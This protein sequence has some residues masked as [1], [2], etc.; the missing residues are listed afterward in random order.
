[1]ESD[2]KKNGRIKLNKRSLTQLVAA[3]LYNCNIKGF[4]KSSIYK[5]DLKGVCVP[6][7][8]CYSCPGAVASCPLGSL[9]SGLLSSRYKIPYYVLGLLILFGLL[10]GRF[11]CGFLCPFGFL[12]DLLDKLARK[13][14]LPELKKSRLTRGLSYLKYVILAVF[15]VAIPLV[16]GVAKGVILPGFCSLNLCIFW[17]GILR[18]LLFLRG[19]L[20]LL[21]RSHSNL[22]HLFPVSKPVHRLVRGHIIKGLDKQKFAN[23]EDDGDRAYRQQV[24]HRVAALEDHMSRQGEQQHFDNASRRML[25]KH[26]DELN[27]DDQIERALKEMPV[28]YSA[29]AHRAQKRQFLHKRIHA[30]DKTEGHDD[31]YTDFENIHQVFQIRGNMMNPVSYTFIAFMNTI[32]VVIRHIIPLS[33][34]SSPRHQLITTMILY[35]IPA[36]F[37]RFFWGNATVKCNITFIDGINIEGAK[38]GFQQ[39]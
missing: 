10:F 30:N 4:M 31:R 38:Y 25:D 17:L 12:Q 32:I 26:L 37:L 18:L 6:G 36:L 22:F 29:L 21:C 1:M 35:Y 2:E 28:R 8:N 13:L 5:G 14:R 19:C 27:S 3:V 11:I 15:V 24:L 20:P 39:R 33:F 23:Y 16:Y 9:Q 34:S 7:L